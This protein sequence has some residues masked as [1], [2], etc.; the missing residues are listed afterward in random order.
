MVTG[1]CFAEIGVNVIC[2]DTNSEKIESLK[3]GV[4]PIYENGLEEMVSR[5]VK[6]GR[7]Q[8]TTSLESC[9][10]E[11]EVVFSAVGTPPDEDGSA[12]LSYVLEVART[13]GRNMQKYV[14]VVTKSTVP[15][16]TARKVR[17]TI[18]EEL[19]KRGGP[20]LL[21]LLALCN[22]LVHLAGH[23]L[24]ARLHIREHLYLDGPVAEGHL[25]DVARLDG[26]TGLGDLAVDED[27][28]CIGHLV[29]HGA[30]LDQTRNFQI[31]IQTHGSSSCHKKSR[32]TLL[33]AAA[34]KQIQLTGCPSGT[35][36]A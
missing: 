25:D 2:V 20:G 8:F 10:N 6:A 16:G 26:L 4:I 13:I 12:D 30:A 5:N 32:R 36:R 28:A 7:L 24:G 15:V 35:C 22:D 3:K 9:L 17:A 29:C 33:Q 19:D 34:A 18:Q 1:T 21:C 11:V 23:I 14:L 31:F 27:A